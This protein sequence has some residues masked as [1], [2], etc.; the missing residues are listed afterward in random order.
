ME[1]I[2][3]KDDANWYDK[4]DIRQVCALLNEAG[5]DSIWVKRLVANNNSKQQVWLAGDPSDLSFL[6]LGVPKYEK[7]NSKKKSS[8]DYVIQIP[9]PWKWV[10]PNGIFDA[11]NSKMCYYP[12]YPE[13]R[14]SGFLQGCESGPSDLMNET[15]R[16]HEE[17]RCLFFGAFKKHNSHESYVLGLVVGASSPAAQYVPRMDTF[18]NGHICKVVINDEN[19]NEFSILES[20]LVNVIN[21]KIVPWRLTNDGKIVKPYIAQNAPGLT[22]EAELGIGE[23][24]IP[25][26]DFDVWEL[27]A[28]KQSSLEKR[29]NHKITLFTPQP[30]IGWITSTSQADFILRYGHVSKEDSDGNPIEY[31]LTS[32]DIKYDSEE[33]DSAKLIIKIIGFTNA[34]NFDPNGKIALIDS[35]TGELAAGWSFLKILEHWQRKHNRVAYVPYV[36]ESVE[37]QKLVEFGPLITLGMSTSFGLFLQAFNDRKIIFDPGDKLSFIDNK[38]KPKSRSQFR[39]NLNDVCA[40][41]KEIHEIDLRDSSKNF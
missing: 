12:Q 25:S 3:I 41:Y 5:A 36:Y 28:I 33:K 26:P 4:L 38:W 39:I 8:S 34:K 14:F 30:D 23:N 21:K 6:P 29:N 40:I 7:S 22:L 2:D 35:K 10:T 20:A 19:N 37:G 9:I 31:Y 27:K 32:S 15:K 18:S 24:A 17:G 16:G 11:P 13:V 1:S